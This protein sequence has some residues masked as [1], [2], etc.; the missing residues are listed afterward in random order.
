[1]LNPRILSSLVFAQR[2]FRT[3]ID[4]C[5]TQHRAGYKVAGVVD[6]GIS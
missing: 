5:S 4:E 6:S 3:L 1:M 2:M